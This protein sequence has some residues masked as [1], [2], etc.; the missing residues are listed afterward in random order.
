V[1]D[2]GSFDLYYWEIDGYYESVNAFYLLLEL[3]YY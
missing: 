3:I 1:Y 2:D